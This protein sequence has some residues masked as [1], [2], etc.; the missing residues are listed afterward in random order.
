MKLSDE[1][2]YADWYLEFSKITIDDWDKVRREQDQGRRN[3]Y[4]KIIIWNDKYYDENEED[5]EI[6]KRYQISG[7]DNDEVPCERQLFYKSK[8][9]FALLNDPVSYWAYNSQTAKAEVTP[10]LKEKEYS[11]REMGEF[12]RKDQFIHLILCHLKLDFP[13]LDLSIGNKN[14]K[15]PFMDLL[16]KYNIYDNGQGFV[17]EIIRG[18][19]KIVYP[20]TQALAQRAFENEFKGIIWDSARHPNDVR[21]VGSLC[22]VLFSRD[23]ILENCDP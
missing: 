10:E 20:I 11:L 8:G 7:R 16:Q 1:N 15:V 14:K 6:T 13:I 21:L 19:N 9:R 4:S 12:Y 22:L 23:G 17:E 18:K 2:K 3:Y 5:Y